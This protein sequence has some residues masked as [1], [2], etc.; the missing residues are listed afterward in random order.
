MGKWFP[1]AYDII[2]KPLERRRFEHIRKQLL[3]NAN[4]IV[5]EIGS[6]TGLNFPFYE[7]AKKV[8]AIEP[9]PLMRQRSLVRLENAQI[10]IE[11]ISAR[12][13]SLPFPDDSFDC[14][15]CTLV[16]C[17]IPTSRKALE[18]IRRV[19]K[20]DGQMLMFEHVK[21]KHPVLGPLQEWMTPLWKRL[22]DGCH[23]NRDTIELVKQEGFK[24]NRIERFYKDI[25]V[26]IKAI[27]KKQT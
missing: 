24:I 18:E 6:G 13:E 10:P 16:F 4:G 3:Q 19:C 25:F 17:T 5:L 27:N 26:V 12:A 2:M 8:T 22:C 14:V 7:H 1:E 9:D 20:P 11:V 21:V 15:V 23:L